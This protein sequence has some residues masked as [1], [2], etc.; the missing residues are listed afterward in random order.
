MYRQVLLGDAS[1][2]EGMLAENAVGQQLVASGHDLH[3]HA[4]ASAGAAERMEVDFLI[5][6]PRQTSPHLRC[7]WMT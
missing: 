2:N 5:V 7:W 3:F 6:S 1:V 4:K